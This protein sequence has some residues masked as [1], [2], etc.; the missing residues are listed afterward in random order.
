MQLSVTISRASAGLV[1]ILAQD[2][3]AQRTP[4]EIAGAPTCPDCRLE[5]LPLVTLGS[6]DGPGMIESERSRALRDSKGRYFVTRSYGTQIQVFDTNGKFLNVI[7]RK[8]GG[9][10]EFLG[11]ARLHIT[12]GDTLHVYDYGQSRHSI[13]SPQFK[14]VRGI[15]WEI[16]PGFI[17]GV[18]LSDGRALINQSIRTPDRVGLPLHLVGKDGRIVKSFG[19]E[20]GVDRPDVAELSSRAIA[21]ATATSVWVAHRTRY[22]LELIDV[23]SGAVLRRLERRAQW[24]PPSE[25]PQS[26]STSTDE[27]PRPRLAELHVD[28]IGRLWILI[29]VADARWRSAAKADDSNRDHIKITDASKYRDAIVEV[30][31]PVRNTLVASMRFDE[32]PAWFLGNGIAQSAGEN[33]NGSPVIQVSRMQLIQPNPIS[34]GKP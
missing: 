11:I 25:I 14:Y 33:A 12:T 30:I 16:Q 5:I 26:R 18:T 20:T 2:T 34:K 7:G 3:F 27:P 15:P 13:F 4:V 6:D 31:D 29:G 10:G 28:S 22:L 19:S 8:G 17:Q 24:F 21:S 32:A 9:P 1:F 23:N